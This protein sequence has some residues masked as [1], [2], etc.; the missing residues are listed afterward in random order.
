MKLAAVR[1]QI[2]KRVPPGS[3][4]TEESMKSGSL[5]CDLFGRAADGR[6]ARAVLSVQGDPANRI[7]VMCV[8]EAELCLACDEDKLPARVRGLTIA[9]D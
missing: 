9:A 5:R 3:G 4:P 6:T 8:C 2:R 7:T 1:N